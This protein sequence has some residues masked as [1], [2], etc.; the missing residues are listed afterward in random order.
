MPTGEN[1]HFETMFIRSFQCTKKTERERERE[2]KKKKILTKLYAHT[3]WIVI[4]FIF[5][6]L[7]FIDF[8]CRFFFCLSLSLS[9]FSFSY[10][11]V[12][13]LFDDT[14][15]DSIGDNKS[16][17]FLMNA[18]IRSKF[19]DY[20]EFNQR[21]SLWIIENLRRRKKK[22][23]FTSMSH[24]ITYE[25]F[26]HFVVTK[27]QLGCFINTNYHLFIKFIHANNDYHLIRQT[28]SPIS[29]SSCQWKILI[30]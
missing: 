24:R 13:F 28:K 11:I 30:W 10:R 14:N 18:C 1:N 20:A 22:I 19:F 8:L 29:L 12:S 15:I 4:L 2:G 9:L 21:K 17:H 26:C 3:W 25:H 7:L 5:L 27:F 6:L 23:L 16:Y